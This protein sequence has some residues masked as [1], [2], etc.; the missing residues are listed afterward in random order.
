MIRTI[1]IRS[2]QGH[3][4]F[5]HEEENNSIQRTLECAINKNVSLKHA[6]LHDVDL[7]GADLHG[8]NLSGADLHSADLRGVDIH[9]A[10]LSGVDLQHA[11]LYSV[12]L[13]Y[14]NLYR[15]NLHYAHLYGANLCGAN[16]SVANLRGVNLSDANLQNANLYGANL[17]GANLINAILEGAN[18]DVATLDDDEKYHMPLRCPSDGS[19]IGWKKV[20]HAFESYLVKLEIPEDARRSSAT[21]NK[22]RCDKAKVLEITSLDGE[23][24]FTEVVNYSYNH[25]T[26]YKVGYMVYPDAF[27]DNRWNECSNGIHFFIDKQEAINYHLY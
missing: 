16:L 13:Q 15:A 6:D 21:T 27:D 18:L 25:R 9:G 26:L 8:V 23:Y 10:D 19:F 14:A 4:I 5:T 22:C 24:K 2:L 7:R 3:V 1:T 11:N 12:N 17:Y 20:K